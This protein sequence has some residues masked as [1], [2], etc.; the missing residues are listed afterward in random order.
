YTR[1]VEAGYRQ[2]WRDYCAAASEGGDVA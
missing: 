2:F 1:S